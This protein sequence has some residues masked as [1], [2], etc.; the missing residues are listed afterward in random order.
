M[1]RRS[2]FLASGATLA[3]ALTAAVIASAGS[4][5]FLKASG[6]ESTL[7]KHYAAVDA[8]EDTHGSKEFWASCSDLGYHVFLEPS[9]G[10]IEEGGD[11]SQSEDFAALSYGDDRYI[12]SLFETRN[13]VYPISTG[14][15]TYAYGIYPQSVVLDDLSL[16]SALNALDDS[17]KGPNGWYLYQGT[18]YAKMTTS[19][20]ISGERFDNWESIGKNKTYWFVCEPIEWKAIAT[21][22]KE[23]Y[24]LSTTILDNKP[25]YPNTDRRTIDEKT[26]YPNNYFYSDIRAFLNNDFFASAFALGSAYVKTTDVD[27]SA[28]TTDTGHNDYA[29]EDSQDKVFLPSYR[30][31]MNV[32]YGFVNSEAASDTRYA[33]ASEYSR[34]LEI[35]CDFSEAS[36]RLCGPYFTRSPGH[37]Y[38]RDV[39]LVEVD[40]L[41]T[42]TA[43]TRYEKG[44]RPAITLSL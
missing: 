7:W 31:Y 23:A 4:F 12:P 33:R 44:I 22:E 35:M 6:N 15:R 32:D 26:V 13:A 29:C 40:G 18:Y 11:F 19:K 3:L 30:D 39:S 41:I 21:S 36:Y 5:S 27:N 24:L 9:E 20:Y 14:T 42:N 17:A 16:L 10:K 1:K 2:L 8:S 38:E 37:G 25:F 43:G 34:A 28:K